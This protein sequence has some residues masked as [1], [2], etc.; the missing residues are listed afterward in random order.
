MK[1]EGTQACAIFVEFLPGN[2]DRGKK[3]KEARSFIS[4]AIFS[5]SR[6]DYIYI[7]I[8]AFGIV[9]SRSGMM[10]CKWDCRVPIERGKHVSFSLFLARSLKMKGRDR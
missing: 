9:A 7:Y 3:D 4:S 8:Y 5:L 1:N 6:V 2:R 10:D